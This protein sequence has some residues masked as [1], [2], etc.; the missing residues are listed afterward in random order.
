[1]ANG[2]S[3]DRIVIWLAYREAAALLGVESAGPSVDAW[4][5][6]LRRAVA[7]APADSIRSLQLAVALIWLGKTADHEQLCRRNLDGL[8]SSVDAT[9][10]DRAAKAYL[11]RPDPAPDTL[12]LACA[13]AH[14]A[15]AAAPPEDENL[16]WF[17]TVA[18]MAAY[19]EGKLDEAEALLSSALSPPLH[20]NQ[21][22]LALAFRAMARWR[23]HR[24]DGARSDLAALSGKDLCLPNTSRLTHSVRDQD[25]LAVRLAG[26]EAAQLL[27]DGLVPAEVR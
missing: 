22:R 25:Q 21:R 8:S 3:G 24:A 16:P 9:L 1:L 18:G 13:A 27:N 7:A 20:E 2:S 5:E 10:C 14:K 26:Y 11:L 17:R 12:K 4:V 19:R 23:A 6:G 15:L